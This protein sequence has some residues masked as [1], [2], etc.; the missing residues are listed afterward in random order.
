ML[1]NDKTKLKTWRLEKLNNCKEF[2]KFLYYLSPLENFKSI[3]DHGIL[4]QNE[5]IKKK[6]KYY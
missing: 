2:P 4:S 3:I 5:T 1:Q 6:I